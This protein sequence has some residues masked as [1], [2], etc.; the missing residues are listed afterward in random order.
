MYYHMFRSLLHVTR[1]LL[2]VYVLWKKAIGFNISSVVF[3]GGILAELLVALRERTYRFY[4]VCVSGQ[5]VE[6]PLFNLRPPKALILLL[7]HSHLLFESIDQGMK[8]PIIR[9]GV[10]VKVN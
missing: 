3:Y 10:K 4:S 7:K 6:I 9:E 2:A 5:V 1:F 8:Q